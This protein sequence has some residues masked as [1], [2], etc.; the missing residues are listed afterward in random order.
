MIFFLIFVEIL[1][2]AMLCVGAAY[3]AI[4]VYTSVTGAPYVPSISAL[5]DEMLDAA[6]ITPGMTVLE[7]GSGNGE[8]AIRAA[9]RGAQAIGMDVNPFL[10]WWSQVRS[11][12]RKT[13]G[14][15]RFESGNMLTKPLP[16]AD[17][18]LLYLLPSLMDRLL[19]VLVK[20]YPPGTRI[21]SNRFEF[22][23]MKPRWRKGHIVAYELSI[24]PNI[25]P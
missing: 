19:P 16:N 22:S 8:I 4:Q 10:V 7:L 25:S 12:W 1:L 18:I 9:E 15:V 23:T 13:G 11:T 17:V 3:A 20:R 6:N 2:L 5:M 21:I 14:R 24:E